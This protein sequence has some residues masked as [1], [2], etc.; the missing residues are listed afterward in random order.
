[1]SDLFKGLAGG[2]VAGL[3]AWILPSGFALGLFWLLLYPQMRAQYQPFDQLTA[4]QKLLVWVF[5]AVL[6]G[7]LLQALSTPMY[8]ILEGYWWPPRCQARGIAKQSARKNALQQTLSGT[9]WTRG[10][11]DERIARFPIP[12]AEI[13]PTRLGNALRAIETYSST[14]FC[15][16]S[17]VLWSELCSLVPKSLQTELDRSRATIDFFVALFYL[18]FALGGLSIATA[19]DGRV[20]PILLVIG[21]IAIVSTI[22]WYEMAIISTSYY[23]RTVQALVNLGRVKLANELGL[24]IPYEIEHERRM[25]WL[26]KSF[27][28]GNDNTAAQELNAVYRTTQPASAPRNVEEAQGRV[29]AAGA[30]DE[31]EEE[32]E[33]TGHE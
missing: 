13:A 22:A 18:S 26:L 12:T 10:L 27:V 1:M 21:L 29:P 28:F 7:V 6:L 5:A 24:Y 31:D 3:S 11:Q 23:A 17:Q 9:G 4:N 16:D 19:F 25:W 8:R 33:E 20:R 32:V 15:L 2:G 30:A 14:R